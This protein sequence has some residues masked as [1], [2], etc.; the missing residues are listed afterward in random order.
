M[1][2]RD[3]SPA[4]VKRQAHSRGRHAGVVQR[5]KQ[6]PAFRDADQ[7]MIPAGAQKMSQVI[8]EF[9]RP[10]LDSADGD[11]EYRNAL[12]FAVLAWN[13][14][15]VPEDRRKDLVQEHRSA[16]ARACGDTVAIQKAFSDLIR[17]KVQTY[18]EV[19]ISPGLAHKRV[20]RAEIPG[21]GLHHGQCRTLTPRYRRDRTAMPGPCPPV[22][23]GWS[24]PCNIRR[25]EARRLQVQV[26]WSVMVVH[27][28][29]LS[30]NG[31]V[32]QRFS[33]L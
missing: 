14:S 26:R 11:A 20:R 15:L 27:S 2:R 1:K 16:F 8:L 19:Q 10:L 4:R 17:R 23:E 25:H 31:A 22:V 32:L 6:I 7:R 5:V 21:G 30:P 3:D 9:A 24:W 28:T 29:R 18:P 33:D 13:A 12:A